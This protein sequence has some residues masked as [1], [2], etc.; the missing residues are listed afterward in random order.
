MAYALYC[1]SCIML[2]LMPEAKQAVDWLE[3]DARSRPD[4]VGWGLPFSWDAGFSDGPIQISLETTYGINQCSIVRREIVAFWPP[5]QG[6]PTLRLYTEFPRPLSAVTQLP[7]QPGASSGILIPTRGMQRAY[8]NVTAMLAGT[9]CT[10]LD[11]F[12]GRE[13]KLL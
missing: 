9:I 12:L 10:S 11:A 4:G 3:K 6:L 7:H 1:S 2:A 5:A 8:S 13:R